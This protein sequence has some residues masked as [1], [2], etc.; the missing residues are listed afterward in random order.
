MNQLNP[1][2][3]LSLET[4]RKRQ[5]LLMLERKKLILKI[6]GIKSPFRKKLLVQKLQ[7][8]NYRLGK[9]NTE[10]N[11][12]KASV[13]KKGTTIKRLPSPIKQPK[14]KMFAPSSSSSFSPSIQPKADLVLPI[15]PNETPKVKAPSFAP[16]PMP[17]FVKPIVPAPLD[18]PQQDL[19]AITDEIIEEQEIID[20]AE[21][22]TQTDGFDYMAFLDDN[23]LMIGAGLLVGLY[24][25]FGRSKPKRSN[26]RRTKRKTRK[27][28]KVRRVRRNSAG[29]R[30][31]YKRH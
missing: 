13:V 23:K 17:S 2:K 20:N 3:K 21:L 7:E 30:R 31:G 5:S 28:R 19:P 27:T 15:F 4:L 8:T 14:V 22:D 18:M 12:R 10:I 25:V 26:P 9:V 11:R 6:K 16:S 1:L 29:A 24:F